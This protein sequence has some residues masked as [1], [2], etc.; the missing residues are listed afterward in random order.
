MITIHQM[1]MILLDICHVYK[2]KIKMTEVKDI[3]VQCSN[4]LF[5]F[6]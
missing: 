5:L 3:S 2:N 1:L 6:C 4:F